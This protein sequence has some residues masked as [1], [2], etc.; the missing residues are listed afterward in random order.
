MP[1]SVL[2]CVYAVHGTRLCFTPLQFL[3]VSSSAGDGNLYLNFVPSLSQAAMDEHCLAMKITLTIPS[4]WA[5]AI[6]FVV[7]SDHAL[8][9]AVP[10]PC[11]AAATLARMLCVHRAGLVASCYVWYMSYV[12]SSAGQHDGGSQPVPSCICPD[13][14]ALCDH[15]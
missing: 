9:C 4:L 1:Y 2:R 15:A 7:N 14:S 5:L 3:N 12:V 11:S 10:S 8:V 13:E 6:G